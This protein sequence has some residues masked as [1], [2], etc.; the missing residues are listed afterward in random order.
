[1]NRIILRPLQPS[2]RA[3]SA[4][5]PP[6]L[7]PISKRAITFASRKPGA[8]FMPKFRP[9]ESRLTVLTGAI[10]VLGGIYVFQSGRAF[11]N[12]EI[13][14]KYEPK[15]LGNH[16]QGTVNK[17]YKAYDAWVREGKKSPSAGKSGAA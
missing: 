10:F 13:A 15:N 16:R 17:D 11:P 2:I 4:R 1:M 12:Q 9:G 6:L 7:P 5:I 3:S 14:D 8:T